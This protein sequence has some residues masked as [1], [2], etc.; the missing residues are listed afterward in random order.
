[1]ENSGPLEPA[2]ILQKAVSQ[3]L[4]L[5]R[6]QLAL[7][8]AQ[9]SEDAVHDLRVATR[10]LLAALEIARQLSPRG[11]LKKLRL[12]LKSRLDAFDDLRDTQVMLAGIA[13]NQ[14]ALAGIEAFQGYLQKR[15]KRLLRKAEKQVLAIQTRRFERRALKVLA[16]LADLEDEG[17]PPRL[18]QAVDR[19]YA[20]V[21][22]RYARVEPDR[23]A[24]IHELRVAFKKFRYMIE[25][26]HPLLPGFPETQFKRMQAYQ[27]LMGSIQDARVFNQAWKKFSRRKHSNAQETIRRFGEQYLAHCLSDFLDQRADVTAFWRAHPEA[28]FPWRPSPE[29]QIS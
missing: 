5:Y 22:E 24:S 18:I 23:P 14:A 17:L 6:A 10:R 3:R 16:N 20:L 2:N 19:A 27:T 15:E 21:L 12:E 25:S 26:V 8:Q 11:A 4:E 29:E 9:F 7:C 1:M 13:E 28:E